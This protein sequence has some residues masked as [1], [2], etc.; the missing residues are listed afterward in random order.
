MAGG[1]A[2]K[3]KESKMSAQ[4]RME[5]LFRDQLWWLFALVIIIFIIFIC[6]MLRKRIFR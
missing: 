5:T 3:E 6:F 2:K 1:Q 4:L